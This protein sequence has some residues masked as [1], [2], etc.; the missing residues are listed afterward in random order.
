MKGIM[1]KLWLIGLIFSVQLMAIDKTISIGYE[2]NYGWSKPGPYSFNDEQSHWGVS[3][4]IAEN[5]LGHINKGNFTNGNI[6]LKLPFGIL[7]YWGFYQA[8]FFEKNYNIEVIN[9][10][11]G[12]SSYEFSPEMKFAINQIHGYCYGVRLRFTELFEWPINPFIAYESY[13]NTFESNYGMMAENI[14]YK[15]PDHGVMPDNILEVENTITTKSFKNSM[16]YFGLDLDLGDFTLTGAVKNYEDWSHITNRLGGSNTF[17]DGYRNSGMRYNL[18]D[19][20]KNEKTK[21]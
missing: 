8:Q 3:G 21:P 11:F 5:W 13:K 9:Q 12:L 16:L 2:I 17:Y 18:K 7:P 19:S 1:K 15:N 6:V 14:Q 10:R 20:K 4:E